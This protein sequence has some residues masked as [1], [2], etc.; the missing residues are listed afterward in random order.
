MST[1]IKAGNIRRLVGFLKR[2]REPQRRNKE[3]ELRLSITANVL[4]FVMLTG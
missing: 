3:A 1:Q 2:K 4:A